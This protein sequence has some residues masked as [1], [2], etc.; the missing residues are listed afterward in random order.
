MF[1]LST[2]NR[3]DSPTR[4][5]K[6]VWQCAGGALAAAA[7]ACGPRVVSGARTERGMAY[8]VWHMGMRVDLRDSPRYR[9]P[10]IMLVKRNTNSEHTTN[11]APPAMMA[12]PR[13]G[14]MNEDT[15]LDD[16]GHVA[17]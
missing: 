16:R 14:F 1:H 12:Y 4:V 8:G 9:T 17:P 10:K 3:H 15:Q 13:Y 11:H 6:G 5:V 2:V 7:A